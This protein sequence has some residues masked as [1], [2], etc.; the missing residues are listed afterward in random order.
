MNK[1]RKKAKS[2]FFK[3]VVGLRQWLLSWRI[4]VRQFVY[5]HRPNTFDSSEYLHISIWRRAV[6]W[7]TSCQILAI[8]A[9]PVRT[10][11][12]NRVLG[13]TVSR[14]IYYAAHWCEIVISGF[15]LPPSAC[16][17]VRPCVS[18]CQD[19]RCHLV[20]RRLHC[21]RIISFSTTLIQYV[22]KPCFHVIKINF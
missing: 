16:P 22:N 9:G 11:E 13:M 10:V 5:A 7:A 4:R 2:F 15:S 6:F 20:W 14:D 8:S 1:K 21:D 12:P 18:A 3:S 17:S 19:K